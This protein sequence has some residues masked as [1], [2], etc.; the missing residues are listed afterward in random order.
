MDNKHIKVCS[1]T[2]VTRVKQSKNIMKN[3][4]DLVEITKTKKLTRKK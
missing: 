4:V 1:T 2:L 3:T